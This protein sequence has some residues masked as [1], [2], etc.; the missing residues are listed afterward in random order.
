MALNSLEAL[1]ATDLNPSGR[2][3]DTSHPS[4]GSNETEMIATPCS[5]PQDLS[6]IVNDTEMVVDPAPQKDSP[7]LSTTI[8]SL[9]YANVVAG[10]SN[11]AL[12]KNDTWTPVGEHDLITGSFN[13]EPELKISK[14][15]K[16]KLCVSW[17][18]TLVV[19]VLSLNISFLTFS[20]KIRNLWRPTGGMEIMALGQEC[21]LIKLSNDADYF[22]ALTEGPWVIFDHYLVFFQWTPEFRLT[23]A[24]PRSMVVWIQFP[25]FPVHFYHK[26]ILFTLGNM[27]GRAIKLDF[28]TQHQQRA[29]FARM[30][31]ELDLSKP[32]VTRIRLD[33]K[34]QY[35]EYENLPTCCFECGKIGHTSV[36][37][38]TLAEKS[39]Q[40]VAGEMVSAQRNATATPPED[41]TGFG[42]WMQVT[43]R[44][45]RGTRA[46]EKGNASEIPG[47]SGSNGKDGKGK[48]L[49]KNKESLVEQKKEI[50][51]RKETG[52]NGA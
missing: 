16:E 36:S 8:M 38:S 46:V 48:V 50:N 20:N 6:S 30:A 1:P 35:I 28:H 5:N 45:R 7:T 9:S 12:Q 52:K 3:P 2:P 40:P 22:R 23:D 11:E 31:V 32:L 47:E 19:R 21:F 17:Q 13:G 10:A 4:T 14:G 42:P 34:W 18:R 29:K 44:S 49:Q 41:R 37:C 25:A 39:S 26:E 43:R 27:V 33:G 51:Q 24:L 15:F